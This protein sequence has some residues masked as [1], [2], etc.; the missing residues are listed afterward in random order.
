MVRLAGLKRLIDSG[1]SHKDKF[2][3][4]PQELFSDVKGQIDGLTRKFYEIYQGKVRKELEKNK[5]F[6]KSYEDLDTGQER[7]ARKYLK[8][9]F[10]RSSRP[11]P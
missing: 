8:P 11:W 1:Y 7:E 5:I 2:G 9:P 10:S 6:F 4:L 3:Y